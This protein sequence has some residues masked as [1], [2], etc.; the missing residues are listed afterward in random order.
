MLLRLIV[1]VGEGWGGHSLFTRSDCRDIREDEVRPLMLK[2]GR[3]LNLNNLA[4]VLLF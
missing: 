4:S 2:D 1:F 3:G